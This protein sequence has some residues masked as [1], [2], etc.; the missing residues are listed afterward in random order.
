MAESS[1][2]DFRTLKILDHFRPIIVKTGADY[3]VLRLILR[4]KFQMDQRRVPMIMSSRA[5]NKESK[6]GN[7][8]IRSLWL[9][10]LMG[11]IMVPF[12]VWDT[13]QFMLQMGIL[14]GVLM[15]MIM[16]SMISDFSSVLLD[17]RDRNIIS[18]KPVN[19]RTVGL[20]RAIHAGVYLF[21]LTGSLTVAPL[22][23]GLITHGI[24]FF[25]L[26]LLQIILISML[27]LVTTSLIYLFMMKF[28]DGEK[29]RDMINMV[30]IIMSVGIAIGYQFVIRSFDIFNVGVVFTP[31]WWQLLLPPLWYASAYDWFFAGGGGVWIYTLTALA[32]VVPVIC[33]I[34]YVKLMP[35]FELYLEKMAHAGQTSSRRRGKWDRRVAKLF[36]RSIEEQACFRLSATMMRNER[37]FKLKVYPS[38]GLALVMPYIIWYTGLQSNTW[39]EFR[40]GAYVYSLYLMLILVITV[41][42][43]LKYSGQYKAAW[44]L[45]AAPLANES[46]LYKGALKAFLYNMFLPLF[47][48]NAIVFTWTFGLRILPDLAIILLTGTALIPASGKLMLQQLPFSRSFSV[49]QESEGWYVFIAIPVLALFWGI[50]VFFRSFSMGVWVYGAILILANVLLW[51]LVYRGKKQELNKVAML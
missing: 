42:T 21:L 1:S 3:D 31:A 15:F 41:V 35:S 20:A 6:E 14:F 32:V 2:S 16:T 8:Y 48:L 46:V 45:R 4:V 49:A 39:M 24:G 47:L 5:K 18:T 50:H 30:Q 23:A 27:I 51:T 34:I 33:L 26:F 9:Y 38:L 37:E 36:C 43:M 19:A 44:I 40:Q 12:I 22:I 25:L 17:I 11:L 7:L 29:L 13:G 28:L 10:M